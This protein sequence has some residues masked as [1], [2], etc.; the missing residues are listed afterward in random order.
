[1][2]GEA[3]DRQTD[4]PRPAPSAARGRWGAQGAGADGT[5]AVL[6]TGGC[7]AVRAVTIV[8]GDTVVPARAT[9]ALAHYGGGR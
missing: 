7:T 2:R 8:G 3:F 4:L 9:F 6:I 5:Q 1:M